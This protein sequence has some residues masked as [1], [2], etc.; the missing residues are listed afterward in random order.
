MKVATQLAYVNL[1][2]N[3]IMHINAT[4]STKNLPQNMYDC[5]PNFQGQQLTQQEVISDTDFRKFRAAILNGRKYS[6]FG[7]ILVTN[8]PPLAL[9]KG[10]M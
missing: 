2:K 9:I 3:H 6:L 8:R 10:T 1:K 7:W 4:N 5:G